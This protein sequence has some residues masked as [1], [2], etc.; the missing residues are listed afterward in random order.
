[1][2][3]KRFVF[4]V[5]IILT[6]FLGLIFWNSRSSSHPV[7]IFEGYE[8]SMTN[9]VQIAKLELRNAT[10]KTIWLS[11]GGS[12]WP[13]NPPFLERPLKPATNVINGFG[14][15][16]Y[17]AWV[18]SYF[19]QVEKL[20]KGES[21]FLDF[22]LVQGK[23]QEQVGICYYTGDFKDDNDFLGNVGMPLLNDNAALKDKIKFYWDKFRRQMKFS[24]YHEVWCPEPLFFQTEK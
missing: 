9:G 2:K 17:V 13:L 19:M 24:K 6:V 10:G 4:L 23:P 5:G 16:Y 1:M 22:P 15:N 11:F 18:G 3:S 12:Q 14:T 21:M 8:S 7:L 20:P